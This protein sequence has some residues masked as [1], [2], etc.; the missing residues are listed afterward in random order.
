[1]PALEPSL[2]NKLENDVIRARSVSESAAKNALE[3]LAVF[4]ASARSGMDDNQR[5]LRRTLR[6]KARQLG[7]TTTSTDPIKFANLIR[8]CAYEQW[9]QMLFAQFL[10]ENDLLM[11][12]EGVAVTFA[13]CAELA[14]EEGDADAWATAARYASHMLPGIFR[15]EDPLLQVSFAL[16]DRRALENILEGIPKPTFTS[17]DGLG[18][19]YQFWQTQAKKEVNASGRKIGGADLP[20]VTQLFTEHYMV[21]FL[22]HNTLGAWWVTRHP[23][24]PLPT[25]KSYLRTLD[26]GTP[27]AGRFE[28]WPEEAK[29]LKLID[30]CCGSGHFLVAALALLTRMRML[31]ENLTEREAGDAVLRDNLHGLELDPRCAQLAAF[32]LALEAWKTGGYRT[33]PTPNVACSGISVGGREEEWTKLAGDDSKAANSLKRLYTMF[34]NAPDLGSLID[35]TRLGDDNPLYSAR[36]EEVEALLDRA[37]ERSKSEDD[38]A[39]AVFGEAARGVTSAANLLRGKYHLVITNVPYLARGKQSEVLQ[40]YSERVYPNSKADLA[41]AFVER[42][43]DYC[44]PGGSYALVT[45]QN[46]LFL[47]RY[48]TLRKLSL[49]SQTWRLVAHLDDGAFETI[50]GGVVR[51]V[52]LILENYLPKHNVS[53][54]SIDASLETSI[55]G[56]ASTL[57]N[58]LLSTIGQV[59]HLNNPDHRVTASN[60]QRD[61]LLSSFATSWQ[62]IKTSDDSRFTLAF[63][64]LPQILK[65]WT[66]FQG[67]SDGTEFYAGRSRIIFWEDGHGVL[68]SVCQKGASF[69]GKSA[70]GKKGIAVSQMRKL[71]ATIYLGDRF[72]SNV[73]PI[74]AIDDQF[75]PAIW[76]FCSSDRFNEEVRK[77]DKKLGVANATLVKVPFDLE[78]WQKV[79]DEQY[80]NGLPEPY[81]DDPTQWLFNG[82]ITG[83]PEPLQ[84]AVARLLGYSWPE[85][86]KSTEAHPFPERE[87]DL[88]RLTD[89][90]GIVCLHASGGERSAAE[91]LRLLLEH[92]YG[93]SWTQGRQEALLAPLGYGGKD[94]HEWLLDGFFAQHCK[95]F[96]NRPFIWHVWDGRKD[97][98]SALVNYHKLT[99][100]RLERLIYTYLGDYISAQ[101]RAAQQEIKGADLRL[102]AAQEL[103]GKLESILH[104]EPPFD[105]YVRWKPK[106][107]QPIGWDP[108]LNDGVRLNVRP[109]VTAGVLRSKFTVHW[110]KDRGTNP[111][112][113]ERHNDINLTLQEKAEARRLAQ[114]AEPAGT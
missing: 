80:P 74:T 2:R 28:G 87:T 92:V 113:T 36:F 39:A 12:P 93:E 110:K 21:Q 105:I 112:G 75:L 103:K 30:P 1:M 34:K 89:E 25:D 65:G 42:C 78:H 100:S 32:N 81:S 114:E 37:L 68:T 33:L 102:A 82:A 26:D 73:S 48:M 71:P 86:G 18:W 54:H 53:S 13:E 50:S 64:E 17:D 38:P 24:T 69:R 61:K 45:P 16:E 31:E 83:T 6:A 111:D 57:R 4:E 52:L 77:L 27:A 85:Q 55:T 7:D 5:A 67:T 29:D 88:S 9:H 15:P 19:V 49:E 3:R 23:D 84:V 62:G 10:L 98:F 44:V 11:H 40:D 60:L 63:W 43:R 8:E 91:R 14:R 79:A 47:S 51:V 58:G 108:D 97:G 96:N 66:H 59:Q 70:W 106:H 95:L 72:D 41:T 90:D 20:A 94:L 35:P 101:T 22:L 109:F 104:G 76:A 46:W 56:K 107:E 99:R